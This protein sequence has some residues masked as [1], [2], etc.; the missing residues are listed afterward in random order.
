MYPIQHNREVARLIQQRLEMLN[1]LLLRQIQ[2]KLVVHLLMHI[3]MLDVRYIRVDHKGYQIENEVRGLS[4]DGEGGEAEVAE[5][6]VV[7]GLVT[8]HAVDH[9]F[10]DF[11]W[12]WEGFGV[13]A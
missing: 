2:P 3:P 10:A 7:G 8:A 11:D 12:R 4:E 13:S 5:A 9:L 1:R 6:G